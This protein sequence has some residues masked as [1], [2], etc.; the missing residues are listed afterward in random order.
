MIVDK[1]SIKF[2]TDLGDEKH[3]EE[4][5]KF[6]DKAIAKGK[7]IEIIETTR[8]KLIEN[9]KELEAF[10]EDSKELMDFKRQ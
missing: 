6:L 2:L 7:T 4:F 1:S 10:K 9:Q 8:I 3:F 5:F